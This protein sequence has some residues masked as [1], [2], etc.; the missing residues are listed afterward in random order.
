MFLVRLLYIILNGCNL[1]KP[2]MP[3]PGA[4]QQELCGK[5][6][7]DAVYGSVQKMLSKS[8]EGSMTECTC[9]KTVSSCCGVSCCGVC[10]RIIIPSKYS[11]YLVW[12]DILSIFLEFQEYSIY[13]FFFDFSI[14]SKFL[15]TRVHNDLKMTLRGTKNA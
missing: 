1:I 2:V 13:H 8:R 12:N 15:Q 3:L 4:L 7:G 6:I 5:N 11:I 9:G 10:V 14:F